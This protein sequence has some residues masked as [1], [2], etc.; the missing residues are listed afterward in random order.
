MIIMKV[1]NVIYILSSMNTKNDIYIC[2]YVY[3]D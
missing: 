2:M 1:I 3:I